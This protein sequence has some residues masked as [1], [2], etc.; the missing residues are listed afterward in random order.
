[1]AVNDAMYQG[2]N[3]VLAAFQRQ[4]QTPF[5]SV[6]KGKDLLFSYNV[7]D[8]EG[9]YNFLAENLTAAEEN[10]NRDILKIKFHPEKEKKFITDSTP[11]TGTLFVR[12][13]PWDPQEYRNNLPMIMGPVNNE[14]LNKLTAMESRLNAMDEEQEEEEAE[15]GATGMEGA[16]GKVESLL[17]NPIIQKIAA[18]PMFNNL[19]S[20]LFGSNPVTQGSI[21]GIP[22]DE[23]INQAIEIL[24]QHDDNIADDLYKLAM[25]A[26]NN[27][28]MFNMLINSLRNM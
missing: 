21:A 3:N 15:I 7:D 11:V 25:I 18:S 28:A 14:I 4:Q 26:K 9:S 24:K 6:W 10:G 20:G 23:K 19:L 16:I 1:M 17:N 27:P 12:V 5:F 22:N 13:C 8:T 2:L